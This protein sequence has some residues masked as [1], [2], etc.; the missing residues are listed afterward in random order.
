[1]HNS[2]YNAGIMADSST[3]LTIR[4]LDA[5]TKQRLQKRAADSGMS[6]NR[7]ALES[8]RQTAGDET[9]EERYQRMKAVIAK[10][11]IPPDEIKR[12]NT[13]IEW[14]NKVSMEKQKREERDAGF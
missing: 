4:G 3:Q 12:I 13:A 7:Y 8:L 9:T 1:M 5:R 2:R 10:N 11:R 14:G 6:L